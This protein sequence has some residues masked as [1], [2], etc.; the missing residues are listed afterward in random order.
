MD[1][2]AIA[3]SSVLGLKIAFLVKIVILR[4]NI[5]LEAIARQSV[6]ASCEVDCAYFSHIGRNSGYFLLPILLG[7][8]L[9]AHSCIPSLH[10]QVRVGTQNYIFTPG[11]GDMGELKVNKGF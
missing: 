8:Y 4:P 7:S 5:E 3:S 9:T 10:S 6:D 2:P 11:H 1:H